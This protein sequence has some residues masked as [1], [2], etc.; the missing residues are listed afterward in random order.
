MAMSN[1]QH[2]GMQGMAQ[3]H[4]LHAILRLAGH[5]DIL[6]PFQHQHQCIAQHPMIIGDHHA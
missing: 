3:L 2:I 6:F 5:H 4:G 1:N